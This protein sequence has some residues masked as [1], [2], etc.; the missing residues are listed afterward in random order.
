M[1]TSKQAPNEFPNPHEV[2]VIVVVTYS[3]GSIVSAH[4]DHPVLSKAAQPALASRPFHFPLV[5][6][7][8]LQSF[9]VLRIIVSRC[10]SS[11]SFLR[12]YLQVCCIFCLSSI[13]VLTLFFY[14]YRNT[15]RFLFLSNPPRSLLRVLIVQVSIYLMATTN[16]KIDKR[17]SCLNGNLLEDGRRKQVGGFDI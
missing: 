8:I 9:L 2:D 1:Q 17:F 3:Q 13:L 11:S 12:P 15:S 14:R 10:L 5:R 4:L 6:I 7:R 16:P